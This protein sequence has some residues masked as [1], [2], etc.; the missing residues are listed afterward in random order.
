MHCLNIKETAQRKCVRN[1]SANNLLKLERAKEDFSQSVEL[2]KICFFSGS[3][4]QNSSDVFS[5]LN[6]LKVQ[7]L[8]SSM[9]YN[10]ILLTNYLD[11]A[12]SFN[13]YFSSTFNSQIYPFSTRRHQ[14]DI[15]LEDIFDSMTVESIYGKIMA[16]KSSGTV[17]FDNLPPILVKLCPE[18]FAR[19]L[20]VLFSAVIHTLVYPEIW[21]TAFIRPLH[22]AGS[23]TDI[24]NYRP[25]SLLPKISLI[26]EKGIYDFLFNKIKHKITPR[27][28]GFQSRKS[29]VLQL[30]DFLET[31][32]LKNSPNLYTVYLDYAKAFDK[33]PFEVLLRK[34]RLF[35]LDENFLHLMNSYLS[36]RQ[37]IVIVQSQMSQPL[38][39][40]SG[41]PQGSV[42]GPLLFLIFINDMPSIFLDAIVWLFADDLKLLFDSLDFESDLVRLHSWNIANGM[43][44]NV[45]KTK[46]LVF[47][48]S[49]SV[50]LGDEV[51]EN[52]KHQKD[53]GLIIS[54]DFKWNN[55]L[56]LKLSKAQNLYFFIR[57]TVPW[58]TP[59]AVKFN[60]YCSTILSVIMYG[61]PVWLANFSFLKRLECF[62]KRCFK[63][64]FGS[65]FTYEEQLAK[66]HCLSISLLIEMRTLYLLLDMLDNKYLFDPST[67][68]QFQN[69][70]TCRRKA[71]NPLKVIGISH[72]Q[73]N[74]F[75]VRAVNS[76]NYLYRHGII[77]FND[78]SNKSNIKKYLLAKDFSMDLRCSYYIC[79]YCSFCRPLL[80]L[81]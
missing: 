38:P 68:I 57:N 35:G 60:I 20:F 36:D 70:K 14:C 81:S 65:K 34:L 59:S 10:T 71:T 28:H 5:L 63:W 21:K 58:S 49:V 9:K 39:V 80:S 22:K 33:V 11:I 55:H 31:A 15:F 62:Q 18:L 69:V 7:C 48:G 47:R 56:S 50:L 17:L 43:L 46:C 4:T 37:Q 2:D 76:F 12:N 54:H 16:M 52:V 64:I 77:D 40:L 26:F 25:I 1:P 24:T 53:L 19:L 41:V 42:L 23:K 3:L 8:P 32:R 79:C 45:L 6:S 78:P 13:E 51:V 67:Y 73:E 66:H 75:F 29:A 72:L 27:Q 44:A 74:S 30:I 61:S